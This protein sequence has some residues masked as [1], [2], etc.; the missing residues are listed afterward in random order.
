MLVPVLTVIKEAYQELNVFMAGASIPAPQADLALSLLRRMLNSWNAQREMVWCEVFETFT[1]VPSL[2][3]HTIGPS[4]ATFATVIRPVSIS[5]VS[6]N[7]NTNTPDVF[8]TINLIDAQQYEALSVPDISTSIPTAV[9]YEA[10]WP[11]G[12]LFFYPIPNFAYPVRFRYRTLL[13][14][15]IDL[16]DTLDFPPGYQD[17]YTYTLA[18]RLATPSGRAVP[19]QTSL[20]AKRARGRVSLNNIDVPVLDLQ[21]G[22]QDTQRSTTFNYHSRSFT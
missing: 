6:L 18:E 1:L 9:Y 16:T 21:D 13:A 22:Q 11:N 5:G 10:D 2:S 20:E 19:L 7:L 8:V 15:E 12:K 17:A 4:A 14:D 3:P